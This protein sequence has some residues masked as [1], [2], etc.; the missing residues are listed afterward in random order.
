MSIH[1]EVIESAN[2]DVCNDMHGLKAP[3]LRVRRVLRAQAQHMSDGAVEAALDSWFNEDW[4]KSDG[5]TQSEKRE[6]M[7]AAIAAALNHEAGQ[8]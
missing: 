6:W 3:E 2:F 1:P 4:K 7:R 8:E 5:A